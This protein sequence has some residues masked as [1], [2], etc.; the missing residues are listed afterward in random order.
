MNNLSFNYTS[1]TVVAIIGALVAVAV[2]FGLKLSQDNIHSILLVVGILGGA[3]SFGGAAKTS[4]LVRRGIQIPTWLHF[5]PATVLS[6]VGGA[7]SIA[8]SFGVSMSQQNIDS[9]MTLVGLLVGGIV[10]GGSQVSKSMIDAGTHPA[11]RAAILRPGQT[12]VGGS[13][14][15][16]KPS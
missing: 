11:L 14:G 2:S 5:T 6:L 16:A 1:A 13:P 12:S 15:Q 8:V 7:I 9:V 3:I 10:L 4:A